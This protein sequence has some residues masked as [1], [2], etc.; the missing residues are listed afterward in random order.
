MLDSLSFIENQTN[1]YMAINRVEALNKNTAIPVILISDGNQTTGNS[2]PF[3]S[4]KKNVFPL[5]IGDTIPKSDVRI[6]QI[7]VNKYSYLK[8]RFPVES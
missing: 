6:A 1:I 2:Y 8:N 7:N 3:I 4:T 5:I